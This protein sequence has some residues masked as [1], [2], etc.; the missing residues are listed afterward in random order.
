MDYTNMGMTILKAVI[1]IKLGQIFFICMLTSC[2]HM[3][4]YIYTA[5]YLST[6]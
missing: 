6:D 1:L 2:V 3:H 5:Q 4:A